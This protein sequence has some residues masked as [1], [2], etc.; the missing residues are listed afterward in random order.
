MSAVVLRLRRARGGRLSVTLS[1]R[2]LAGARRA[3]YIIS[4]EEYL[5][6]GE[7]SE[8]DALS[9]EQYLP[10]TERADTAAAY[11]RAVQILSYGDNT[12]RALYRK[13]RERGFTERQAK[14]AVLRVTE[15]GYIREEDMLL[16][17]MAV[18]AARG[19]GPLKYRPAL[20]KKGFSAESIAAAER[21]A[22]AE[23]V[24][25]LDEV[26]E[27]LLA[28]CAPSDAEETHALLARYG[29]RR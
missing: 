6:A 17:Q 19:D 3:S 23:G 7:F 18:F 16:R 10:F 24:Y 9:E 4:E 5:A 26:R 28:R 2:A 21:R 14:C 15:E 29:F 20:M 1:H 27:A 11:E 12:A 25:L 22:E 13:L 8:G